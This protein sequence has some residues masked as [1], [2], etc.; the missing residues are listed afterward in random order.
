MTFETCE[1][2]WMCRDNH[3]KLWGAERRMRTLHFDAAEHGPSQL[4][5]LKQKYI[6]KTGCKNAD[7]LSYTIHLLHSNTK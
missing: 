2:V 7:S 6:K 1:E 3:S 5:R 4:S